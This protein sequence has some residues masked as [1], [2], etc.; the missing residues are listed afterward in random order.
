MGKDSRN[1]EFFLACIGKKIKNPIQKDNPTLKEGC[2]GCPPWTNRMPG[3][4]QTPMSPFIKSCVD[5]GC[6]KMAF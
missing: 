2:K 6:T 5:K 4:G 3:V 1:W